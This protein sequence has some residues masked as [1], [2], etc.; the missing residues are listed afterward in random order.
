MRTLL[1]P[2][3]G[4]AGSMHAGLAL[5][6]PGVVAL[7]WIDHRG[8]DDLPAY[9]G[10]LIERLAITPADAVGGSSMGGMVA[11]EIHRQ[12]GCRGLALIGS[13]TD[14]QYIRPLLRRL[15]WLGRR[16]PFGW[17]QPLLAPVSRWSP[18]LDDLRRT[19]PA[20]L[21]WACAA[22]RAWSGVPDLPRVWR[23]HGGRDP[24]ITPRGQ[25]VDELIPTGGHVIAVSHTA[26]VAAWLRRAPWMAGQ[27]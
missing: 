27:T 2:G 12:V 14:P 23:I 24:L 20:F 16:T 6:V 22:L 17:G 19:D 1:L 25:P 11:A 5:A 3:M 9:A 15:L 13:C 7:D 21:R 4:A 10:R 8:C 26:A 18:I